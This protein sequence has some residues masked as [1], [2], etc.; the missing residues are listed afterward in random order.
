MAALALLIAAPLVAQ[1]RVDRNDNAADLDDVPE[2]TLAMMGSGFQLNTGPA[3]VAWNPA[4]TVSGDYTLK[5]TFTLQEPSDHNNDLGLVF[6][7][8]ALGDD[9]QDHMYFHTLPRRG[10]A[11]RADGIYGVRVGHRISGVLVEG[12][13]VSH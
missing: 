11:A 5:G 12:R 6:G 1:V 4:N 13:S 7:A 3:T 10:M 9:S 8:G 2:V